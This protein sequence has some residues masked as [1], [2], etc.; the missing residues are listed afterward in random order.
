M[1]DKNSTLGHAGKCAVRAQHH[2][3]QVVVIANAAKHDLGLSSG[4]ARGGCVADSS[5]IGKLGAPSFGLGCRAVV[6]R[7]LMAGARQVTGHGVAHHAQAQ[8]G[9]ASGRSRFVGFGVQ[10]A[11][12]R[13]SGWS[14]GKGKPVI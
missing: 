13:A 7:D 6:H 3:T 12:G 2:A 14:V 8:K 5:G 4:F 11:H 10:A 9:N 1:I